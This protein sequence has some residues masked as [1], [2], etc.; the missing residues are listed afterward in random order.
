MLWSLLSS[1][2]IIYLYRKLKAEHDPQAAESTTSA[3]NV[4]AELDKLNQRLDS[5]ETRLAG[6]KVDETAR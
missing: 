1:A 3:G 5:L 4:S 2:Y 6:T